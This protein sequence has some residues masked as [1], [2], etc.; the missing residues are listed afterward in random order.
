M[1]H[2]FS[3]DVEKLIQDRMA[4][5]RYGSEEELL[6]SALQALDEDDEELKAIEEGLVS[7]D[8]GEAG[9]P[10]DEVFERLRQRHSIQDNA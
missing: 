5:G 9:S 4:S 6:V 1:T 2:Q 8:R 3:A 10:L 7:V